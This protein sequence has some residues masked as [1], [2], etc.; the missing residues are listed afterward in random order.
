[1]SE[2][3][4]AHVTSEL[5]KSKVSAMEAMNEVESQRVK[6]QQIERVLLDSKEAV[7]LLQEQQMV[8]Q[9]SKL[10]MVMEMDAL[11]H[12][13]STSKKEM[14]VMRVQFEETKRLWLEGQVERHNLQEKV[15]EQ[16]LN[17]VFAASTAS[18][19]RGRT[20][21]KSL[22]DTAIFN[23]A[24]PPRNGSPSPKDSAQLTSHCETPVTMLPPQIDGR[25]GSNDSLE[26]FGTR[27]TARRGSCDTQTSVQS[28][29]NGRES[30][31]SSRPAALVR[32]GWPS[33]KAASVG[34]VPSA[35]ASHGTRKFVV[36]SD[37]TKLKRNSANRNSILGALSFRRSDTS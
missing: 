27:T 19:G 2:R 25:R 20:V 16:E 10:T 30:I 22:T 29:S 23:M 11:R 32:K 6:T 12:E 18:L 13:R 33:E 8:L 7:V 26:S 15:K 37:A 35:P 36:D 34:V 24:T 28:N 4:L 1:M 21:R 14:D 5:V 3:E 17:A 31:S 9:N